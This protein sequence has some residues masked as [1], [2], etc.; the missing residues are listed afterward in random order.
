MAKQESQPEPV[1]D[2]D[3]EIKA[4]MGPTPEEAK[5]VLGHYS[6]SGAETKEVSGPP[7]VSVDSSKQPSDDISDVATKNNVTLAEQN[8]TS[9]IIPKSEIAQDSEE[10]DD[11][12]VTA[13]VA[14]IVSKEGDEILA[15]ED[16]KKAAAEIPVKKKEA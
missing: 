7:E 15:A 9:E 10:A 6:E 13:A 8:N 4:I 11:P 1:N 12:V 5:P 16:A 14:D 3:A 2:V